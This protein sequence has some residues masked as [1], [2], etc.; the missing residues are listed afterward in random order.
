MTA[1]VA[2]VY[3]NSSLDDSCIPQLHGSGIRVSIRA[4]QGEQLSFTGYLNSTS[5]DTHFMHVVVK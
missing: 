3:Q 5:K 1:C 4:L 2:V